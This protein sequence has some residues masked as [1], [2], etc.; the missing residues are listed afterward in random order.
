MH[1]YK[2]NVSLAA[3]F[4]VASL[5][6]ISYCH[7]AFAQ[8]TKTTTT[9]KN[10]TSP[11]TLV[12]PAQ[13]SNNNTYTNSTNRLSLTIPQGWSTAE[14]QNLGNATIL[15]VVT[16]SP[17]ISLDPAALAGVTVYRDTKPISNSSLD[18]YL[19]GQLNGYRAI[20]E[21]F[22]LVSASTSGFKV[23][24][25]PGYQLVVTYSSGSGPFKQLETGTL[26]KD[27]AFFIDYATPTQ[28]FPKFLPEAEQIIKSLVVH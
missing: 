21:N 19:R 4:I 14:G 8:T 28:L 1:S 10:I 6:M 18:Q 13:S 17:P 9:N 27:Q 22:K 20:T 23:S 7:N 11:P 12:V 25:H 15:A 16:I 2:V 3:T 26:V 5:L 24:G